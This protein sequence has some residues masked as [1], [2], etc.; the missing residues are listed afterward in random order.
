MRV[1]RR[2][3]GYNPPAA[4]TDHLTGRVAQDWMRA[5]TASF[6]AAVGECG[7]DY[8]R[9]NHASKETQLKSVPSTHA[10]SPAP[11]HPPTTH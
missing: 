9:L 5:L 11:T 3:G 4:F 10:T 1:S 7:L 8:A 6:F 2:G